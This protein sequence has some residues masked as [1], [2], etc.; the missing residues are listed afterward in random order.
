MQISK[1]YL[2]ILLVS[3]IAIGVVI[4][5]IF[6]VL[7]PPQTLFSSN[8]KKEKLNRLI[9][10][11]EYEYI[12]EVNTDSIV[13]VTVNGILQNLDPHSV[14]ISEENMQEVSESMKG[15][16][17]GIGIRFYTYKDSLAVVQT[18]K[19]GPSRRVGIKGGDRILIANKDTLYGKFLPT[20]SIISKLKGPQYS[21]LNLTVFRKNEEGLLQFQVERDRIPIPSVDVAYMLTDSLAYIKINRFAESTYTEFKNALQ[22]VKAAGATKLALDLR[23]N[24]GGLIASATKIADEFLEDKKLIVVTK[25]KRGGTTKSYATSNGSFENM[26]LYVL[27][28]EQ[29]ASASEIIAGALQDNDKGTIVGRRSFGKGLI[30][31]EMKLGDGSAVRLTV[32]RYYTPT[33][34]SIQRSYKEGTQDY[35]DEYYN[36]LQSGELQDASKIEVADS[37]QFITPKGKIVYGGGGIIPDVFVP[38]NSNFE[39]ETLVYLSKSGMLAHFVFQQLDENRDAF[40]EFSRDSFIKTYQIPNATLTQ[41]EDFL[42]KRMQYQFY[43]KRNPTYIKQYLKAELGDQIYGSETYFEIINQ[44]D[45]TVKKII[46]LSEN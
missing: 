43:F 5:D 8:R 26:P 13:E 34:R 3:L 42:K 41:L 15:D 22:K 14:Y 30:Q 31:R 28:D 21:K 18:I 24:P 45:N 44:K 23:G 4:E 36:R 1:K 12:D 40:K 7:N 38:L 29:T 19:N 6:N 25:N 32:A 17:V 11:I 20:D 16:F 9:D 39:N 27:I 46:E 2:P 35:Y 10:Y 33:G 37:L